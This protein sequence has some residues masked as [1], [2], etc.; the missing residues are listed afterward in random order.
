MI[1]LPYKQPLGDAGVLAASLKQRT[2]PFMEV[3]PFM[4]IILLKKTKIGVVG[5][6]LVSG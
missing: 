1:I 6:W 5:E 3:C 2:C 4:D